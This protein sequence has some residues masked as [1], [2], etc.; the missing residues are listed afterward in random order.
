MRI[1]IF[2]SIEDRLLQRLPLGLY[3][4]LVNIRNRIRKKKQSVFAF[5]G[6]LQE[7]RDG[8]NQIFICRRGRHNRY[9]HGISKGVNFLAS[10]Y[11]LDKIQ[12]SQ[13]GL[14]IDCGANVGELGMWA[15]EHG[16]GYIAFEPEELE[17]RC[18]DL[19]NFDGQALT[20]RKAL[21]NEDKKLTFFSKPNTADG[22]LFDMGESSS[23][24]QVEAVRLDNAISLT[25]QPGPIIFKIEAEG[26]EPEVLEGASG[27][28]SEIDYVAVDC[29]YERGKEKS[30]TFIEINSILSR[31]GFQLIEAEFRR[32]TMLYVNTNRIKCGPSN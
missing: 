4:F 10:Q 28:L 14:L 7:V 5:N 24:F 12:I 15:R 18:V 6:D 23:S 20:N 16:L 31:N 26:A 21:W 29:G 25:N 3:C 2:R 32:V 9:K 11:H 13:G 30:H 19:N 8:S 27:L 17:A 22:S 1:E